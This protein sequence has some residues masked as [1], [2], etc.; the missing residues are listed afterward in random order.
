MNWTDA[1]LEALLRDLESQ[2]VE[3]K[4]SLSDGDKVREAICAFAN[5]LED[6]RQPGVLFIGARDDGSPAG[7]PITDELLRTLADMKTDGNLLPPPSLSVEKRVLRGAEMAVVSV[8]PSDSPPVRFK[9]R[10]WVRTGP[11]RAIATAQDERILNEKRR[12]RDLPFDLHPLRQAA[13]EDLDSSFFLRDYLPRAFAPDVLETNERSLVERL[14]ACRMIFTPSEPYPTV[15]GMLTLGK[16]ARD[17]LPCAYVQFLRIDGVTLSEPIK[18]AETIDGPLHQMLDRL[19]EKM[20]ANIQT[21]IDIQSGSVERRKPDY[22]LAALQQLTRNAIMHRS[23]EATHA[24]VRVTWFNDRIE[25][26][27]P[28]G[29]YGQVTCQNFGQP[30]ITDYRNPHLAE[31]LK[32]LGYVQRFGVGIALAQDSLRKNGNPPARFTPTPA[33]VHV[34]IRKSA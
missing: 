29:P 1:E 13:L 8:L 5:D 11:R 21:Q 9:G 17:Y 16:R 20:K 6:T 12:Y 30:G 15:N 32:V 24:P 26:Q 10:I 25:I 33:H 3:R 19:D 31:S 34:E 18:D 2:R 23:Y 28:G 4:A 22:P 27:N 14:A 7:L